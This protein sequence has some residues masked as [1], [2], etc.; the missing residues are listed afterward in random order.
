MTTRPSAIGVVLGLALVAC[1]GESRLDPRCGFYVSD[2]RTTCDYYPVS[3]VQLVARPEEFD[4]AKVQLVG[5]VHLEFEGNAVYLSESDYT[6]SV[7]RNGLWLSFE[8][9]SLNPDQI[10]D[11]FCLIDATFDANSKGH[12]RLFSG[13]LERITRIAP[14]LPLEEFTK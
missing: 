9:G 11:R 10:N 14:Q 1:S 7:T 2:D 8:P 3:I 13:S 4:G 12:L 5:F 6:H